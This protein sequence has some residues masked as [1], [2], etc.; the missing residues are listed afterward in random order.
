[1]TQAFSAGARSSSPPIVETYTLYRHCL[2]SPEWGD[3][4]LVEK[5]THEHLP[6]ESLKS[7]RKASE[8]PRAEVIQPEKGLGSQA[9]ATLPVVSIPESFL[10]S[11]FLRMVF[12]RSP[13][14]RSTH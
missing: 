4:S 3:L 1:M 11:P 8:G 14:T 2:F 7:G 12:L 6:S 9:P 10:C 5:A 13:V